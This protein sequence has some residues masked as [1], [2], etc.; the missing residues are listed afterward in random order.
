[1]EKNHICPFLKSIINNKLCQFMCD[2]KLLILYNNFYHHHH[3]LKVSF[4]FNST[5]VFM[6]PTEITLFCIL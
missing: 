3:Q 2:M 5:L 1:M 4:C 6:W